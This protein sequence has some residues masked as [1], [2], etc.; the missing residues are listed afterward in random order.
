MWIWLMR[1]VSQCLVR[2]GPRQKVGRVTRLLNF[3]QWCFLDNVGKLHWWQ[4]FGRNLK[5]KF[6]QDS[7]VAFWSTYGIVGWPIWMTNM[8]AMMTKTMR[9]TMMMTKRLMCPGET[10]WA[11]LTWSDTVNVRRLENTNLRQ[12]KL[13]Q[14]QSRAAPSQLIVKTDTNTN[15][16]AEY[17]Y[18]QK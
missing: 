2:Q 7:E 4:Y 6:G 10:I 18:K 11:D 3:S 15:T 13:F 5:L 8:M 1:E 17:K 16:N 14:P 12:V 9:T